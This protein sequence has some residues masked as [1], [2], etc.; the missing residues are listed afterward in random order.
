MS[1]FLLDHSVYLFAISVWFC[2]KRY[3]HRRSPRIAIKQKQEFKERENQVIREMYHLALKLF[4]GLSVGRQHFWGFQ[5]GY[6]SVWRMGT[7]G[8]KKKK[9][10]I[11]STICSV[12]FHIGK[13]FAMLYLSGWTEYLL[14]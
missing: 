7:T 3:I 1:I 10:N 12:G 13:R 4:V 6:E 9:K 8:L 5:V 14:T 11:H 2:G